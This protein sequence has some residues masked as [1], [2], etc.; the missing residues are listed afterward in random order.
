MIESILDSI[1]KV[2]GIDSDYTAFDEDIIMHINTV[3]S[4]L[5]ELGVGPTPGFHIEDNTTKWS[6]FFGGDVNTIRSVKTYIYLRVRLLFDPPA[7]SFTI[8]A[9]ENQIKELEW[10]LSA[11][12][13][14]ARYPWV[15]PLTTSS[16][17]TA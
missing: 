12:R 11:Q 6:D 15:D 17:T 2:L 13:E 7:T 16:P 4:V 3:F 1:K 9:M 10:R 5:G 14:E 8:T